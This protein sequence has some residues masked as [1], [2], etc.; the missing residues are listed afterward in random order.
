M[1]QKFVHGVFT[2]IHLPKI[3]YIRIKNDNNKFVQKY[4]FQGIDLYSCKNTLYI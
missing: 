2:C 1:M 4:V 3:Y